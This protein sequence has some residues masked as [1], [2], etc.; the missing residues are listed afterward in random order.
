MWAI[1]CLHV[2][3]ATA[4]LPSILWAKKF[5][6]SGADVPYSIKFTPDGGTIAAGYTT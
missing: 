2:L 4:Q 1:V 3:P 5:G 6:G